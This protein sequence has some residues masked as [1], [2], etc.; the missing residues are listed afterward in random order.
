MIL[1]RK[2]PTALQTV[3]QFPR[4]VLDTHAGRSPKAFFEG[5]IYDYEGDK[6]KAQTA[7]DHAR[8]VTEQLVRESPDDAPLRALLGEILAALGQKDAAIAEGKRATELPPESQDAYDGPQITA[9]LAIIYA[10]TGENDKALQLLNHLLQTPNGLTVP[11][12]KL[13]PVWDPLRKDARFQ[14]LINKYGTRI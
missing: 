1:Q 3:Q 8:V 7:F 5:L 10:C 4:E 12:L 11:F 13:D 14:T 9:A 2:F 6:A